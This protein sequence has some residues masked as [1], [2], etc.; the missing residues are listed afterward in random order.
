[1]NRIKIEA[2]IFDFDGTICDSLKIK[3]EIFGELYLS[4]GEKIKKK[5]MEF[6]RE[7]LGISRETKFIHFQKNIVREDYSRKTITKL[8]NKFSNLVKQKV[9]DAGFIS[10]ALNFLEKNFNKLDLHLSSA[11]PHEELIEILIKKNIFKYFKSV[12]GSPKTKES[13]INELLSN[14]KFHKERVVYVGD[15]QHDM[16]AARKTGIHFIGI[17]KNN[18][19]EDAISINN[20]ESLEKALNS[21]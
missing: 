11:T 1:M 6:H 13:H 21:I 7:N 15:S 5:V 9:I 14:E 4:Y 3:E 20:L 12:A 17:G 16:N 19:N 10:G 18:F 8:S 2:V